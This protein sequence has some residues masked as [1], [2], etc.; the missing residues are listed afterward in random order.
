M[1]E[2][3]IT[4]KVWVPDDGETVDDA[5]VI[6]LSLS[7]GPGGAAEHF[8]K[9]YSGWESDPYNTLKVCVQSEDLTVRMYEIQVEVSPTFTARRV[10]E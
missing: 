6:T 10:T 1:D 5:S 2:H 8:A 9:H 4:Y 3:Y 7:F